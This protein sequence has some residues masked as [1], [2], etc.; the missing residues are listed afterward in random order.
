[1]PPLT[2]FQR[3]VNDGSDSCAHESIHFVTDRVTHATHLSM[4]PFV[5]HDSQHA[6]LHLTNLCG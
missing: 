2:W 3:R 5:N 1:M 6:W 4:A